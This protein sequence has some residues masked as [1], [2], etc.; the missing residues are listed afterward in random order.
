[1][2]IRHIVST[3]FLAWGSEQE[4][5]EEYR[6]HVTD[7]LLNNFIKTIQN[8]TTNDYEC[9]IITRKENIGYISSIMF[10]IS[11]KIFT[12][13]SLRDDIKEHLPE[14]DYIIH[15]NCDYDDFFYKDNLQI[16]K[17]SI[18]PNTTFKMYGFIKGATLVDGETE[19]HL[20]IPPYTGK[21]GFFSCCTSIIYSTKLGFTDEFPFLIHDVAKKYGGNHPQWK[22]IIEKEHENWGLI[23]LDD[24]FFDY[25]NDTQV[26]Y[27]WIRQPLSYTTIK[28]KEENKDMHYSNEIIQ[29]KLKEDFGYERH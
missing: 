7:I 6:S 21:N 24:D 10:P 2:K 13:D 18:T 19:A 12:S 25:I 22:D 28:L 20:F 3:R 27:I 1:M 5:N 17:E 23:D 29:L 15:T 9:V 8:Q 26:R 16:I 4:S 14:Y 11:I